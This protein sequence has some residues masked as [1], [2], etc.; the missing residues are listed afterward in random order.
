MSKTTAPLLSFGAS[1]QVAKTVVYSKWRGINYARRHVVPANPRT[2][3]QVRNRDIFATLRE[4]WKLSPTQ[5]RAPWAAYSTGRKFTEMNAFL[6]ENRLAIGADTDWQAL[7]GS[8]GAR[9]GLPADDFSGTGGSSAGEIDVT[10][11]A[12]QVPTGWTLDGYVAVGIQDQDP[13]DRFDQAWKF[14]EITAPTLTGTITGLPA[15]ESCVIA[16]WPTFTRPD[17]LTAFGPSLNAVVTAT[18]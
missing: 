1:G 2:V 16:G 5:L 15:G 11:V 6:G 10:F 18:A 4:A 17:G 8:P 14:V 9:G 3:A 12:P 13:S 7:I